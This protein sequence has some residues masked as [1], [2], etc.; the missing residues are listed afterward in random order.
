MYPSF[1]LS[2]ISK[3]IAKEGRK[4][5]MKAR[6][7]ASCCEV[8]KTFRATINTRV[9]GVRDNPRHKSGFAAVFSFTS[10]H[11]VLC[12]SY[13]FFG[14]VWIVGQASHNHNSGR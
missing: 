10:L 11:F 8:V 14:S 2:A 3:A 7:T 5:G 1:I 9:I 13:S 12:G 4:E 6:R